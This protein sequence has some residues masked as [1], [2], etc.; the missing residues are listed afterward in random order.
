[1]T[2]RLR[3]AVLLTVATLTVSACTTS[4]AAPEVSPPTGPLPHFPLPSE[5]VPGAPG[6]TVV[7]P[8]PPPP[9]RWAD[10]AEHLVVVTSGSSSCP[11]GPTDLVV[12]GDQEIRLELGLLFPDRDPCTADMAVRS[13]EVD[14]PEGISAG[15]PLDVLLEHEGASKR[16]V[17]LPP[18]G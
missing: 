10:D 4:G 6:R 15:R 8:P 2:D 5:P 9:V 13:T 18:D 12:V 14:V 3:A 7:V 16:M 17:L 1:M 11:T